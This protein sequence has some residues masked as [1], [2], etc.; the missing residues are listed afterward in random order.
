MRSLV[1]DNEQ[2]AQGV[3]N[4]HVLVLGGRGDELRSVARGYGFRNVYT[5]LDIL[6]WN[7]GIWPFHSL[8]T[9]E[10]ESTIKHDFSMT[11]ITS[12]FVMHDP[13]NWALD[14][15]ILTDILRSHPR[16]LGSSYPPRAQELKQYANGPKLFFCNP[17][18]LWK[19]G[20]TG[21][22]FGQ[23][24]FKVAFQAAFKAMTGSEYP[25]RQF[26]KPSKL[27]FDYGG[28]M[29]R[30][31]C[32]NQISRDGDKSTLSPKVF[33]IGDNP[34]SDIAGANAAGWYSILV[35]TGVYDPAND[36]PPVHTPTTI[37]KDVEGAVRWAITHFT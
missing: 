8:T 31:Q 13:R 23:G 11:P 15:Q 14:I 20:Y 28:S 12:I 34:D 32:G 4:E 24:A 7:P 21:P 30:E 22:R 27:T 16:P 29:L 35:E 9:R 3:Q 37:A 2:D 10:H 25:Y 19:A 36:T 6:A 1:A 18:L 5:T 33:M 17:D 26:G